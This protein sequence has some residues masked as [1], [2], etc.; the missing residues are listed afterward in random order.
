MNIYI[1]HNFEAAEFLAEIITPQFEKAGHFITSR[2]IFNPTSELTGALQ[3]LEDID[4]ADILILYTK[5]YGERPGRG[6]YFEFGYALRAGKK[7]ILIGEED[8]CVF[9]L[10]PNIIKFKNTE[11]V[12]SF[13]P[14]LVSKPPQTSSVPSCL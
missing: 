14:S 12:I 9:Y 7:I 8:N 11:N 4:R 1:A 2:W 3:D 5:Q 13:L 10:L 6:K